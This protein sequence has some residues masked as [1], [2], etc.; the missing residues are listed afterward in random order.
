MKQRITSNN[1]P[2]N[3]IG[4]SRGGKRQTAYPSAKSFDSFL[5]KKP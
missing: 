2:K 5:A 1:V 4:Y 3:D